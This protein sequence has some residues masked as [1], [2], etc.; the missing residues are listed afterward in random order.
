[1]KLTA[2]DLLNFSV[3]DKIIPEGNRS[4]E[5]ICEELKEALNEEIEKLSRLDDYRR[6][7]DRYNKFRKIGQI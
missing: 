7:E 5:E 1:M 4:F 3:A 6:C 2:Q